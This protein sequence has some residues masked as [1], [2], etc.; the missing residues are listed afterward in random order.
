MV[1]CGEGKGSSRLDQAGTGG[2]ERAFAG[3]RWIVWIYC[4]LPGRVLVVK[5]TGGG[6]MVQR[7]NFA[8]LRSHRCRSQNGADS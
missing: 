2:S 1:Q 6:R 7:S 4:D 8:R 3:A 5:G